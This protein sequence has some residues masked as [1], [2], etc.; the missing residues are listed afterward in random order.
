M[1]KNE[2]L[3]KETLE[4]LKEISRKNGRDPNSDAFLHE[5]KA[6]LEAFLNQTAD[7][8]GLAESIYEELEK[9]YFEGFEDGE[10]MFKDKME[11]I[12]DESVSELGEKI[13]NEL[14]L[15][16]IGKKYLTA[17][18]KKSGK[19]IGKMILSLTINSIREICKLI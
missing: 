18:G 3:K 1:S 14:L 5:T 9:R 17:N 7:S 15:I 13:V 10:S 8:K 11:S 6:L 16:E 19:E 4:A 2:I 12:K